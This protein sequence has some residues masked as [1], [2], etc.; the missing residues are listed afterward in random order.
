MLLELGLDLLFVGGVAAINQAD[1]A[2][3][4]AQ[5]TLVN[6]PHVALL[7]P[8]RCL[9]LAKM[10]GDEGACDTVAVLQPHMAKKDAVGAAAPTTSS[11]EVAC[12]LVMDRPFCRDLTVCASCAA[13]GRARHHG[14]D[15]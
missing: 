8:A 11:S 3:E 10:L 12:M 6:A 4:A 2:I 13:P 7:P 15:P 9:T 5:L 14:P 1:L